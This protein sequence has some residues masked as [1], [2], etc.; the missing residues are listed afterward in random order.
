MLCGG[1]DLRCGMYERASACMCA[2][3]SRYTTKL[4][5]LNV[6]NG[7]WFTR[8]E[9]SFTGRNCPRAM[10]CDIARSVMTS[11]PSNCSDLRPATVAKH[12]QLPQYIASSQAVRRFL[13]MH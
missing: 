8:A 7:A 10:P 12:V 4:A 3:G 13:Q 1:E 9:Y 5:L 2:P 6:Y 11:A